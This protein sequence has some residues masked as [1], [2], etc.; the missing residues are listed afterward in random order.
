MAY[1]LAGIQGAL[2][3]WGS[4]NQNATIASAITPAS[5]N[6][7]IA[8]DSQNVTGLNANYATMIP[9]LKSTSGTIT[10]FTGSTP[11]IAT[12]G[13]VAYNSGGYALHIYSAEATLRTATVHDITELSSGSQWKAF[14]PDLFTWS[15]RYTAGIDNTDPI[16]A[17][18]NTGASLPTVTL[19]Y[20]S[21]ATLIGSGLI[22]QVTPTIVRGQKQIATFEVDGSGS[23]ATAGGIFGTSTLGGSVNTA[24]LWA[25]GGAATGAMVIT[26]AGSRTYTIADSFWTAIKLSWTPA[27]AAR[28]DINWQG[29][30]ALTIG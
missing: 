23:L 12:S 15:F 20:G 24:P 25:A 22:R 14:R 5:V 3:S 9:G 29:T 21:G 16:V 19:T 13:Q 27:S 8:G 11:Y 10:G 26:A 2:T 30:G 4:A 17:P 7:T 6:C 28:V 1:I 18:P